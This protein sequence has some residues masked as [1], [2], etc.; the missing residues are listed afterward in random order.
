MIYPENENASLELKAGLS[1]SFLKTVSAYANYGDGKIVFGVSD[2]GEIIGISDDTK[3]RLQIENKINASINPRPQFKLEKQEMDGKTLVLLT[4]FKGK[5]APYYY[6]QR[7][8]KRTDTS[9]APV[10][11][12]EMR[13]LVLAGMEQSYDQLI[14]PKTKME[15][16]ILEQELKQEIGLKQFSDDTLRTLGLMVDDEYTRAA[17]LLADTNSN[18]RSATSIVRFGKTS[19][20]FLDRIDVTHMSLLSQYREALAMFDKWYKP[21]EEVVGFRRIERI[22]IPREAYR[23]GIANALVNRRY[24][25]NGRV[26]VAMHE[27][28][29]EIIS[30]G[31]LPE[32][33]SEATY[34]YS[35]ISIPR[36]TVIADIF[37]RLHIIEKFG[38]GID[39][40]RDAYDS[41][42]SKPGFEITT[43]FIRVVLPV[44]DYDCKPQ[45]PTLSERI[46]R[47]LSETDALS[48]VEIEELTGFK[49]TRVLKGLEQLIGDGMVE[50]T[51]SG[52]STK[53]RIK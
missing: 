18:F 43:G 42:P 46:L 6:N 13:H 41:F 5:N 23:E 24:D 12:L 11:R 48:R 10:D 27:N 39:R 36:N 14:V 40:I 35:C 26:Q 4:V 17:E 49:R 44:I 1:D 33:M 51:G 25:I 31:G 37:H 3:L 28:R 21:Y 19:S 16:N 45:E 8:F 7:T 15:F 32:G 22:Q 52:P 20:E 38:T 2:D 29:I 50:K 9:S 34:L 30:P 47:L 53:Y